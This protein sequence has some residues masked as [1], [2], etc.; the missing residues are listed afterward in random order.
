VLMVVGEVVAAAGVVSVIFVGAAASAPTLRL[1][2][3]AAA[4]AAVAA[5]GAVGLVVVVVVAVV[6]VVGLTIGAAETA[7]AAAVAVA[8]GVS[9]FRCL[10]VLV[11]VAV[12]GCLL[13]RLAPALENLRVALVGVERPLVHDSWLF[14]RRSRVVRFG[15]VGWMIGGEYYTHTP[16][17]VAVTGGSTGM[18]QFNHAHT[19]S[20][21]SRTH[22]QQSQSRARAAPQR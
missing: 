16:A 20:I 13:S 10:T 15:S 14:F 2:D 7:A 5:A 1:W 6:V 11:V 3:A 17:A 4:A 21:Q 22:L 12:D 18:L 9:L 8:A 19:C